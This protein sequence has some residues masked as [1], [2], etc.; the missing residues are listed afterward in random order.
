[1]SLRFHGFRRFFQ[2]K[3]L[4]KSAQH[5]S[6]LLQTN[7]RNPLNE[8]RR[9]SSSAEQNLVSSKTCDSEQLFDFQNDWPTDERSKLIRDMQLT[10]DFITEP[11]EAQLQTEFDKVMKRMRYEYDHWDNAIH[12]YREREK[13]D[14]SPEN[15]QIFKR[16][17]SKAFTA[18]IIP[19]VHVLDLAANGIIKPHVDSVRYCGSTI[20]GISLLT[21]CIMRLRRV[22]ENEYKQNIHGNA[23]SAGK[24]TQDSTMAKGETKSEFK[25]F[26]D[27]LLKRRSLY[28]MKDTARY[29][30]SHEV[31]PTKSTFLGKEIIKDRRVS[32]ICR[33]QA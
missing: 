15:E 6:C 30:F 14:W 11:E 16:I 24:T 19:Q 32:I 1:M 28:I 17:H 29:N 7:K 5:K 33:N 20:A 2:P 22:D 26:V 18:N 8:H 31:L 21:D 23:H 4:F 25:H 3:L 9:H 27:I 10:L 12:G 13:G